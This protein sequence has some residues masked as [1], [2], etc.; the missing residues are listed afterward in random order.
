MAK[1]MPG[2][3]VGRT[4]PVSV[5]QSLIDGNKFIKWDDVSDLC[6]FCI[7]LLPFRTSY[8]FGCL[9]SPGLQLCESFIPKMIDA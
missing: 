6:L 4:K 8:P 7:S 5:P 3:H 2:V 1:V 9:N